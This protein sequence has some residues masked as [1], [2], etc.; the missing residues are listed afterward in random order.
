MAF[1]DSNTYGFIRCQ[2]ALFAEHFTQRREHIALHE[3]KAV[4]SCGSPFR[5]TGAWI[6]GSARPSALRGP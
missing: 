6:A 4:N 1:R 3:D 2:H 5:L